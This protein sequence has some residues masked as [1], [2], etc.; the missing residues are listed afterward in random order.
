MKKVKVRVPS[1]RTVIK[2]KRERVGISVCA[3]CKGQLHGMMRLQPID[4]K[5]L[6]KTEKRPTRAYGGYLCGNCTKEL[7]KE[8]ARMV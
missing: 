3:N 6:S 8:K 4:V 2:Q 5:K 7:F 1:G